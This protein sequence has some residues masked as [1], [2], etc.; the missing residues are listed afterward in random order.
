MRLFYHFL[1]TA[2]AQ[3]Q[4]SDVGGLRS[5]HP[6]VKEKAGRKPLADIKILYTDPLKLEPEVE[7]IKKKYEAAFGT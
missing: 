3:Q 6:E 5:F 2:Q 1:F 4:M 7:T